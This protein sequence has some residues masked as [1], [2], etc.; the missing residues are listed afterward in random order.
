MTIS[1]KG[2]KVAEKIDNKGNLTNGY[3]FYNEGWIIEAQGTGGKY[4]HPRTNYKEN[5]N[6]AHQEF[7]KMCKKLNL[8]I[9]TER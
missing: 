5:Y 9:V 3:M 2:Y 4:F 1:N 8:E 6:K 7:L